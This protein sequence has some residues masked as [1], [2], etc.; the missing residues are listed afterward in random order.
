MVPR[1]RVHRAAHPRL[2]PLER[3]DDGRQGQ[4]ARRRHRRPP[5]DVRQLGQPVRDR[6]QPLL[7]RQ[8]RRQRR[9]PR[10][11]PGPR[12]ARR[13]RPGVPRGPPDRGRPRPLPPRDRPRRPRPVELPAPA[14]D[15]RLLGVPDGVAWASARS[16]RCT[17]PGSTATC[18][19]ASSTTPARAGCGRSSATA[20]ATSP[21]RSARISLASREKLDNLVFVVNCN[22]QR[23]D[24]PVRGNGKIIQ[25]LEAVF[26]G[27][28][29]N[30][31]K[32]ILGLEVGRA[33]GQGQGRCAAQP[34]EQHRRR[35][36]PALL[37]RERRVHPGESARL[38]S[39]TRG[40][41]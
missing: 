28:G 7:P 17:R 39:L 26:R 32:V 37:H 36:V 13:L 31:I 29:W 3:G 21:R 11:L 19:T 12:R 25:E 23:L 20:S 2:R 35:P 40:K 30:V 27:A 22:L 4:Q 41:R 34:D 8:G 1:R 5:V 15:A 14:A 6:L 24:G 16:P 18:R 9:R 38:H 33:A 10:L